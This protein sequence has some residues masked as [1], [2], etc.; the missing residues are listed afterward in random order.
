MNHADNAIKKKFFKLLPEYLVAPPGS[1][2]TKISRRAES[3][4]SRIIRLLE[5]LTSQNAEKFKRRIISML[6]KK[7]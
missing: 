1:D 3:E 6:Q 7:E 2:E 5:H 4:T